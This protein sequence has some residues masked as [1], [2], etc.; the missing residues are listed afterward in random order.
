MRDMEYMIGLC[1][2]QWSYA[3]SSAEHAVF[4]TSAQKGQVKPISPAPTARS[5]ANKQNSPVIR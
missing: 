5:D 3:D 4:A 1:S 2:Q